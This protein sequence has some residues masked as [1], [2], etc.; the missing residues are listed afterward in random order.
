MILLLKL[1]MFSLSTAA[2]MNFAKFQQATPAIT[3]PIPLLFGTQGYQFPIFQILK[4][5]IN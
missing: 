1:N 2:F 3:T 4:Y 5:F